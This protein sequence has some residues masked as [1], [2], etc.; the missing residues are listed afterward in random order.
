MFG[1]VNGFYLRNNELTDAINTRLAER[2][3]VYIPTP[4]LYSPRPVSTKF[5]V[6]PVVDTPLVSATA[7]K[8]GPRDP[9][10]ENIDTDST[11]KNIQFAR[12]DNPLLTYIPSST[13]DLY[14]VKI[15]STNSHQPHPLLFANVISSPKHVQKTPHAFNNVRLR[16]KI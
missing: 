1:V 4:Y 14:K 12:Q 9:Y 16:E 13:S 3:G 6:L 8:P 15:P 10:M 11:L 2:G 7:I 5:T